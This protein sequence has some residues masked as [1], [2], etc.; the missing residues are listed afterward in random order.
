MTTNI[1][2]NKRLL[3][4]ILVI[5]AC[6]SS[7]VLTSIGLLY[8][9]A[10]QQQLT[11]MRLS[12]ASQKELISAVG[13][14]DSVNSQTDHA[15]GALGG[16]LSQVI[17]AHRN[18]S[19]PTNSSEFIVVEDHGSSFSAI[20]R[21]DAQ[22][23]VTT[24]RYGLLGSN[25]LLP[26][27]LLA[28][29]DD[30][31]NN[32]TRAQYFNSVVIA[33]DVVSIGDKRFYLIS[34]INN[35]D[36]RRPFLRALVITLVVSVLLILVGVRIITHQINPMVRDLNRQAAF[37]SAILTTVQSPIIITDEKGVI[38]NHN[39]ATEELF[40][41]PNNQ[42]NGEHL[43]RVI[44]NFSDRDNN[45]YVGLC[46][47]GTELSIQ[48]VEGKTTV[49]GDHLRVYTATDLTLRKLGESMLRDSMAKAAAIVDTVKDGIFTINHKGLI[50]NI[51]PSVE[52]IFGYFCG[53]L[54]GQNISMLMPE[55]YRSEH[56]QYLARYIETNESTIL[57]V[58]NQQ[59]GRH[60]DGRI[61][62][63]ELSVNEFLIGSDRYFTGVVR[64]ISD[65][66]AAETELQ[67]H[68]D[69]LQDMVAL[70]TT[71][72]NAIVR[73]AVNGII[74][75]DQDGLVRIF[76]PAAAAMFGWQPEEIVG[77]N[78]ATIIPSLDTDGHDRFIQ[79]YLNSGV[80]H[81]IGSD[82]EVEAR[83]KD[84]TTFIALLS[85]G[86]SEL[87][88][89]KH[90]F[91][92]SIADI[93]NQKQAQQELINAKNKAEDAARTKANFL[94]NMSHEIR[95]PMNAV[96]GF[97]EVVLQDENLST[98]NKEHVSTILS[99][100]KNLLNIINDILDFSKV[101]SGNVTLENV[102]F[103]LSNAIYDTL[104]TLQFKADEKELELI[105]EVSDKLPLRVMGDPSRLRQV[106]INL[107]GNSIKFT[108]QGS[109]ILSV[110]PSNDNKQILFCI[111]DTGIGMSS[112]QVE[113]I[114]DAFSQADASTNR[115]YGG[116]GLGTTISKQLIELMGGK[117]W[118]E[119][120][121]GVG[122][123]FYFTADLPAASNDTHCLF[124]GDTYIQ[125]SFQSPRSFNVLLAEDVTANATLVDIRLKRQ[126]HSVTWA[127][128]GKVA[129]KQAIEGEFDVVLMDIQMP[130]MDG[131]EATKLI[132][133]QRAPELRSLPIIALTASVMKEDQQECIDAGMNAIVGKPIN[134]DEL[135]SVMEE[136]VPEGVGEQ[137]LA[138]PTAQTEPAQTIDFSPVSSTVNTSKG[139]N[140]WIEPII[141]ASALIAFVEEHQSSGIDIVSSL[142][143]NAD[144]LSTPYS[145][146]HT[147]K[148]LAGNLYITD[149][150]TI[151]SRVDAF[152]K[153]GDMVQAK[154][155]AEA[156]C[157]A[158][159]NARKSISQ[160]I[161]PTAIIEE[162]VA[163]WD[164]DLVAAIIGRVI[165][166]LDDLNPDAVTPHLNS[167]ATYVSGKEIGVIQSC[168]DSFDFS[169]AKDEAEKLLA[170]ITSSDNPE[171]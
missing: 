30:I 127:D 39:P 17:D 66:I 15:G 149:V 93:T 40:N 145:I 143:S 7:G 156:L 138:T 22:G 18:Y 122:S 91:V 124:E 90:L 27:W 65:R 134:F 141:Y 42:L 137:K 62:P 58:T 86:H 64:D 97:S 54:E 16:T 103:H 133:Q 75:I 71:E 105:C 158:L 102:C 135:L 23:I 12:V 36:L 70:A 146:A 60:K 34:K 10:Y 26:P 99:S 171:S 159:D 109:I 51:N 142:N 161:L 170:K 112:S 3:T 162:S 79:R 76:N 69:N 167:L 63:I 131:L 150:A 61:F 92:A 139:L 11:Q 84:G 1:S 88:D 38:L 132:R 144:D 123:E 37:N 164:A 148:G 111:K 168:V 121:E 4:L 49:D 9:A 52:K 113:T 8:G 29:E 55:P 151:S 119:S 101:E 20:M 72:T 157:I 117:I 45:E 5:V 80:A 46:S 154:Q 153:I 14:F 32:V 59:K 43:S 31:R 35:A 57:G 120:Q 74:S 95:T 163:P 73:T 110:E 116:T 47:D 21:H 108:A 85:V 169:S 104:R 33:F 28:I 126:G 68:R 107:I 41:Y 78:V 160:L 25:N 82:R 77:E 166:S 56:D 140:V 106:I 130:E 13:R 81:I 19:L 100:G 89:G 87:G 24:D 165:T 114:F 128:N 155:E 6:V 50:Q 118:I 152:L 83:R 147:L 67:R 53:E 125:E 115:R 48:L 96:I 2:E 136:H 94:A 98:E 129:A 44:P